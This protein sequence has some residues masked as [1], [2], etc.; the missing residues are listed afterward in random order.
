MATCAGVRTH[1]VESDETVDDRIDMWESPGRRW[2]QNSSGTK[3]TNW[4]EWTNWTDWTKWT[5]WT[6]GLT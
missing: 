1:G 2:C 3:W 6:N 5:D 4:T